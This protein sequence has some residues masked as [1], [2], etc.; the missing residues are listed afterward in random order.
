MWRFPH[1]MNYEYEQ[2]KERPVRP[3]GELTA[4]VSSHVIIMFIIFS[5]SAKFAARR[6]WLSKKE[7]NKTNVSLKMSGSKG[8]N[9]TMWDHL[10]HPSCTTLTSESRM[11]EWK[12]RD[13]DIGV[14]HLRVQGFDI[15]KECG[16]VR[17]SGHLCYTWCAVI[18][19]YSTNSHSF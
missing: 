3:Y 16:S 4:T 15:L 13:A 18:H 2:L 10:H 7:T 8:L 6:I 9:V 11:T 17:P 1:S 14:S 12:Q 19:I 5:S